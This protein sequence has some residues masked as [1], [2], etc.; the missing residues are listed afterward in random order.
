[1]IKKNKQQKNTESKNK[2]IILKQQKYIYKMNIKKYNNKIKIIEAQPMLLQIFEIF[3]KFVYKNAVLTIVNRVD[4]KQFENR[5]WGVK[6]SKTN[7]LVFGEKIE[8][9]IVFPQ[10][11]YKLITKS[12][13]TRPVVITLRS[14]LDKYCCKNKLQIKELRSFLV[15][16]EENLIIRQISAKDLASAYHTNTNNSKLIKEEKTVIYCGPDGDFIDGNLNKMN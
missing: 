15:W 5:E 10:I 6:K 14:F 8:H 13:R 7:D 12:D 9:H 3:N 2:E 4:K 16:Q 11:L 1:M